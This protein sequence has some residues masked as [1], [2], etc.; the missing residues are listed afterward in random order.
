MA[1]ITIV[2][3]IESDSPC[4]NVDG[5]G[6]DNGETRKPEPRSKYYT[7]MVSFVN[8]YMLVDNARKRQSVSAKYAPMRVFAAPVGRCSG[9]L[10]KQLRDTL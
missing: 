4:H 8:V 7:A 10:A 2:E 6:G 9:M 1:Q 5:L 3:A